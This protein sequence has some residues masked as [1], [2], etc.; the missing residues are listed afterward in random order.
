M[1]NIH[2]E[3]EGVVL[4]ELTEADAEVY[5]EAY[6]HSRSDIALFDS[7]ADAKHTSVGVTRETLSRGDK[8]RLGIWDGETFAGSIN[9]RSEGSEAEIGYWLDSRHTGNGYATIAAKALTTY[10]REYGEHSIVFAEVAD[11]NDAS[12]R[13]LERAG[14]RRSV[15]EAGQI[16]FEAMT[17][18]DTDLETLF[19]DIEQD[20]SDTDYVL[21]F[22]RDMKEKGLKGLALNTPEG[23]VQFRSMYG[24]A[25]DRLATKLLDQNAEWR[26]QSGAKDQLLGLLEAVYDLNEDPETRDLAGMAFSVSHND[27]RTDGVWGE[28][29][30]ETS[31]YGKNEIVRQIESLCFEGDFR[32]EYGSTELLAQTISNMTY[33]L[34]VTFM[35]YE[36]DPDKNEWL[37]YIRNN[38]L[39]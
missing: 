23:M 1:I 25:W 24:K 12:S 30:G 15:R 22:A 10:A 37:A 36:E 4:R 16:I 26:G 32:D 17:E 18:D 39:R 20:A 6:A 19:L 3:V 28:V 13:V 9:L 11:G 14:F 38:L 2:T 7:E 21:E 35:M 27:N 8:L 34:H 33:I 31:Y 5:H 29:F